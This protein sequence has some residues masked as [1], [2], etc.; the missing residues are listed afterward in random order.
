MKKIQ[1]QLFAVT[2]PG[3]E[4]VCCNEL[5]TLEIP[6]ARAVVGGVEFSG[7]LRE[8]YLANLWLR[9]ATR[10]LVRVGRFRSRDFPDLF[11]KTRGLPWG[12]FLRVGDNVSI[13]ATSHQSRLIHTGR[14]EETVAAALAKALGPPAGEGT[15]SPQQVVVRL[16]NDEC[17]LSVD[18]SGERLHR[19]GYRLETAHAPLRE[20]L[21][22]GIL[23]LLG[24][25]GEVPLVDPMCGS[26]TFP[27]EAA[28]L[29]ANQPPGEKRSFA[30][31]DWPHYRPGLW[32]ALLSEAQKRERPVA[33]S[34]S[35]GDRD[36][37]AV[38][39]ARRNGER[40]GVSSVIQW[41]QRDCADWPALSAPGL[42]ICNPPYGARLSEADGLG[43]VYRSLGDV[44]RRSFTDWDWAILCPD[45]ALAQATGLELQLLTTLS[46]G[47]IQ[48]GLWGRLQKKS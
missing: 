19:R 30:F 25:D 10:V 22:A 28:L 45:P 18:S 43:Q 14:V 1:M 37:A 39:A 44:L 26:G 20:T 36:S 40:A 8:L 6:D 5:L 33:V 42:V 32:Q 9:S 13:R 12:R 47:G 31:M 4:D 27:I 15:S 34:L 24:W 29:A 3:L 2:A 17:L 38:E 16:D 7:G 41:L 23:Q 46:N 35:G 11:R 21:A 48:V